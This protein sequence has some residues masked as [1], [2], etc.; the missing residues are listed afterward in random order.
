M[1]KV[2]LNGWGIKFLFGLIALMCN[3]SFSFSE[4]CKDDA[5]SCTP[6]QLCQMTTKSS[7][8]G[9][10]WNNDAAVSSHLGL[11][12]DLGL[13]CGD[14]QDIC[15]IDPNQCKLS[16]I[17]DRATTLDNG[18]LNWNFDNLNH[19]V[20]AKEYGLDC[21][22]GEVADKPDE[23]RVIFKKVD[24]YN[25]DSFQRKQVQYGLERLG[26]YSSDVDG[27][28]G[29]GTDDAIQ[30]YASDRNLTANFPNSLYAALENEVDLDSFLPSERVNDEAVAS[31]RNSKKIC[32]LSNPVDFKRLYAVKYRKKTEESLKALESI[33]LNVNKIMHGGKAIDQKDDKWRWSFEV[34]CFDSRNNWSPCGS[35][36]ATVQLKSYNPRNLE[37]K[38]SIP[39]EWS[40]VAPSV[41]HLKYICN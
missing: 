29:K 36:Y 18:E 23:N 22:V 26:Y 28:W 20:L 15:D 41:V 30:S 34:R 21:N 7:A 39:W 16:Q 1:V 4:E 19:V 27:V 6:K 14:V 13:N 11:V 5:Y 12:Q 8:A 33:V 31:N 24:F 17:C 32:N 35:P 25:L 10:S 40:S 2:R 9:L 37:G 3:V 38:I